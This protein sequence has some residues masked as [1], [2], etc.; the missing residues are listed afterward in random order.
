MTC[1]QHQEEETCCPKSV[2]WEVRESLPEGVAFELRS[3]R[4]VSESWGFQKF[5]INKHQ[6]QLLPL[7]PF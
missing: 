3:E 2:G 7:S 1:N 4:R 5:L 6:G